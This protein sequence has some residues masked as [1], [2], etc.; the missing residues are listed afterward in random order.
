MKKE[1]SSVQQIYYDDV[2][3]NCNF[4]SMDDNG[5]EILI[6]KID[7]LVDSLEIKPI[8]EYKIILNYIN[9]LAER[10]DMELPFKD[11]IEIIKFDLKLKLK[12]N[13]ILGIKKGS[14]NNG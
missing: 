11:L 6:S 5:C 3:R 10:C 2:I 13:T 12:K 8:D 4:Y 9:D 1:L 14:E 7:A